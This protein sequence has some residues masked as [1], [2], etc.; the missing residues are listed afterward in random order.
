MDSKIPYQVDQ[1]EDK[2]KALHAEL[3]E[4]NKQVNVVEKNL[5]VL[6]EQ[7]TSVQKTVGGIVSKSGWLYKIITA[8]FVTAAIGWIVAGGLKL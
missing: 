5:L 1:L 8:G 7:A 4:L 6:K 3:D 2:V